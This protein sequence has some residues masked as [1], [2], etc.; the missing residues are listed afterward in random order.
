M[1]RPDFPFPQ[2][3]TGDFDIPIVGQ[4]PGRGGRA[5]GEARAGRVDTELIRPADLA[6]PE[7]DEKR[8]ELSAGRLD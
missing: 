6:F 2:I 1:A 3:A 4:Q 7:D 8:P 5:C